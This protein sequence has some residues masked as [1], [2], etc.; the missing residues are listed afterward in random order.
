M[1]ELVIP[2]PAE[3]VGRL[4]RPI[5]MPRDRW[6]GFQHCQSALQQGL[7]WAEGQGWEVHCRRE[8]AERAVRYADKKYGAGTYQKI[9]RLIEPEMRAALAALGLPEQLVLAA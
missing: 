1:A 3:K 7:L 2:I 6:G 9:F 4:A 8:V 5:G